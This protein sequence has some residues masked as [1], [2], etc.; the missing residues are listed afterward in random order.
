M[1]STRVS[2]VSDPNRV[3]DITDHFQNRVEALAA[4]K[5]MMRNTVNQFR[6][7]LKTWG[8]RAP[9]LD[10]AMEG[11]LGPL[12]M[13]FLHAQTSATAKAHGLGEGRLAEEFRVARF[14]DMEEFFAQISEP[15]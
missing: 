3:E 14:G 10:E 6:L 7:Q 1:S 15:I 11:D 5:T 2:P 8:R 12:L 13:G 4:H 9:L